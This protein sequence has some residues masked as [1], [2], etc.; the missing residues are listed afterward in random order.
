MGNIQRGDDD[1]DAGDAEVEL[2]EE[3]LQRDVER[4]DGGDVHEDLGEDGNRGEDALSFEPPSV[5]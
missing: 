2:D 5:S 3:A 4:D 1:E